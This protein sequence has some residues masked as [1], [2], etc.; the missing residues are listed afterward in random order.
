MVFF[1]AISR[2]LSP[3]GGTCA[4]RLAAD[5]PYSAARSGLSLPTPTRFATGEFTVWNT[6]KWGIPCKTEV[7]TVHGQ[8]YRDQEVP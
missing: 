8:Q 2:T 5:L 3:L 1:A 6:A 7:L 4:D